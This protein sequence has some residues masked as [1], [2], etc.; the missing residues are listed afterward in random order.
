RQDYEWCCNI[1]SSDVLSSLIKI[2]ERL[3]KRLLKP[4]YIDY[5]YVYLATLTPLSVLTSFIA[6]FTVSF[7]EVLQALITISGL[8]GTTSLAV[9]ISLSIYF[10]D[11]HLELSKHYYAGLRDI[12]STISKSEGI[13]DSVE[14]LI[15]LDK[16]GVEYS[17]VVLIPAYIA[18]LVLPDILLYTVLLM[19]FSAI[20][21]LVVFT[22]YR[23][24]VEHLD[25]ENT[26]EDKLFKIL[27]ISNR[28]VFTS[29][30]CSVFKIL[31]SAATFSLYTMYDLHRFYKLMNEH[32]SMH[33]FNYLEIK[34]VFV[35][36]YSIQ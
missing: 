9:Y 31:V 16:I 6:N 34:K 5:K 29:I 21:G 10:Y 22:L 13:E 11:K 28:R 20:T 14:K 25:V 18:L 32:L 4:F 35:K 15:L 30:G 8:I 24:Y 2:Q 1:M 19:I 23:S 33:R 36:T 17:P 3:A 7:T 27:N 12:V 26:I